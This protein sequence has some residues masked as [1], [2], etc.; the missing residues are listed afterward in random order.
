MEELNQNE[1]VEENFEDSSLDEVY[2]VKL[3]NFEGPLDL[4]LQIIRDNKMDIETVK[5][6]DITEQYLSYLNDI[7]SLD[8]ESAS[9]FIAI[10]AT[11]IEIK[12]KSL[13]P[14]E[15]VEESDEEDPEK[16]LIMRL[17]ELKLFKEASTKLQNIEDLDKLYKAP[18]KDVGEVKFVLKDMVLDSLLDA[19]AMMLAKVDKK[20][21]LAEPKKITK[22]RFTVAEKISSITTLI[23]E[24]KQIKFSDLFESD[25]TKSELVNIFLALLELL[26]R[27][28]VIAKQ[29]SIFGE[30]DILARGEN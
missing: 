2:K 24:K 17:K 29:S 3:E 21:E 30:I 25:Q 27:Q 4:L 26:K 11:L 5:L 10:A 18:D 12:S 28:V 13:L 8:M 20:I 15:R 22:D 16:Q 14:R 19:F 1:E 6:A 23:K 7:D 9:E